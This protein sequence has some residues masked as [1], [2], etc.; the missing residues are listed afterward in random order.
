MISDKILT[1][2][3]VINTQTALSIT[4]KANVKSAEIGDFVD[5]TIEVK[6]ESKTDAENVV[7]KDDL[8]LG[9]LPMSK[10]RS[11]WVV[12]NTPQDFVQSGAST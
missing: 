8:P 12:K 3:N 5:Y 10:T 6:N 1:S 9:F 7:V 11:E 2:I 4:K